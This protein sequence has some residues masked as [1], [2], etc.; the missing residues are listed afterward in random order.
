MIYAQKLKREDFDLRVLVASRKL[1]DDKI[2]RQTPEVQLQMLK[3]WLVAASEAENVPVPILSICEIE[4]HGNGVYH[5]DTQSI[6]LKKVSLV[7][8]FH[9]FRHHV[10]CVKRGR[11]T[12]DSARGWSVSLFFITSPSMYKK[13]VEN[14]RLFYV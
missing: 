14:R 11:S 1:I 3:T 13:A 2:F 7:T 5:R 9:E 12:E 4:A 6:T 8:L 10:D